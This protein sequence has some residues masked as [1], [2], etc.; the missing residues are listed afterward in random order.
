MNAEPRE[1]SWPGI[2]PPGV[3]PLPPMAGP[4]KHRTASAVVALTTFGALSCHERAEREPTAARPT[5]SIA[6]ANEIPV[7]SSPRAAR[8]SEPKPKPRPSSEPAVRV[9]DADSDAGLAQ[10]GVGR[11]EEVGPAGPVTASPD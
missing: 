2:S 5:A 9:V 11:A 6:K 4:G 7:A 1:T 8:S 3:A 10:I